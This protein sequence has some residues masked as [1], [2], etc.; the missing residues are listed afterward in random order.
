MRCPRLLLSLPLLTASCATGPAAVG[1]ELQAY[2]AGLIP[3]LHVQTPLDELSSLTFRAA[4]NLT[5]RQDFGEFDN[6]EGDGFGGGIGYRRY[7]ERGREGWLFGGRVDLWDLE[8]DWEDPGPVT[9]TTDILV[10][11]PTAEVGYGFRLGED[12][13]RIELTLGLGAE[14][15]I[16]TDGEDVGEGAILLLGITALHD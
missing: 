2:P 12:G 6:E 5:D 4:A 8:I 1:V 3:G 16:D 10:L 11:Q 9:G 14:I 15:N 7:L 13:W